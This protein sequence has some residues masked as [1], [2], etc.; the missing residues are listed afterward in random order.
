MR[1]LLFAVMLFVVPMGAFAGATAARELLQQCSAN[2][3]QDAVGFDKLADACPGMQS[4]LDELG[5]SERLCDNC[6]AKFDAKA[7]A[8]VVALHDRYLGVSGESPDPASVATV[9]AK[10]RAG[11]TTEAKSWWEIVRDWLRHWLGGESGKFPS[12]FTQWLEKLTVSELVLQI[13]LCT[14]VVIVV[15]LA[16]AVI[17]VEL[18]AAGFFAKRAGAA[19]RNFGLG[20]DSPTSGSITLADVEAALAVDRPGMMLRLLISILVKDNR[21]VVERN[22]THRELTRRVQFDESPNASSPDRTRFQEL[23]L[24]AEAIRYGRSGV[25]QGATPQAQRVMQGAYALYAHLNQLTA[26]RASRQ[27]RA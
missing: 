17:V 23:A 16:I 10:M 25:D 20:A 24:L 27:G 19:Q 8:D 13:L 7:L 11:Q 4:A 12:W 15:G 2:A 9:L 18:R 26:T 6:A 22:L 21:L 5:L 1:A 14:L 3:P